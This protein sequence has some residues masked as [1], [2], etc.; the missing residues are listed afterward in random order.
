M[1]HGRNSRDTSSTS[2]DVF[3]LR[4][5]REATSVSDDV[6]MSALDGFHVID[7]PHLQKSPSY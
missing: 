2:M 1:N 3:L 7:D 6:G 4:L 5:R